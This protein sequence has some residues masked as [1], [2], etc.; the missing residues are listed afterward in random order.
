MDIPKVLL[1]LNAHNV[2]YVII[3][4]SAFPVH[5][6]NRATQDI[7]IFIQPTMDNVIRTKAALESVGYDLTDVTLD[8]M[9]T[10]KI[11]LRQYVLDTDIHP[12]A[13]GTT[14]DNLWKHKVAGVLGG[15][16]AWFASLDDLIHMKT[17]AG[18]P[19]D[20]IDLEYLNRVKKFKNEKKSKTKKKKP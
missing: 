4:A 17:A 13:K 3:G 2:V 14:F 15:V 12:H 1:S 8:E 20:L 7:D 5:G 6:Y 16:P 19:Q 11:L 9:L 18:R 10:K